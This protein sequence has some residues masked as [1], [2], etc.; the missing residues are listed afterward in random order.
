MQRSPMAATAR[1]K[2]HCLPGCSKRG[3]RQHRRR[4]KDGSAGSVQREDDEAENGENEEGGDD[5]DGD[6]EDKE[7]RSRGAAAMRE[8]SRTRRP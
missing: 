7:A 3:Y 5:E 6:D 4:S 8:L 2:H 1:R